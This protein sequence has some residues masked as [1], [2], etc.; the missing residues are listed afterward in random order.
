MVA[1]GALDE[2]RRRKLR[3]GAGD[4]RLPPFI[5]RSFRVR[6][7]DEPCGRLSCCDA[8]SSPSLAGLNVA[9]AGKRF[10]PTLDF[11]RREDGG[12]TT[13]RQSRVPDE[14][15]QGDRIMA[16]RMEDG[17][18]RLVETSRRTCGIVRRPGFRVNSRHGQSTGMC[19]LIEH[20]RDRFH[21]LRS[22]AYQGVASA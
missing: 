14:P 21:Q 3:G 16:D 11:E 2:A 6:D 19:E 1:K 17:P 12:E 7:R 10:D 20:V 15:V 13:G 22:V 9:T 4:R 18:C 5:R 8:G